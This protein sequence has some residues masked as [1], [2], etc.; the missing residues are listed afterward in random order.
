MA[1]AERQR[2]TQRIAQLEREIDEMQA[3]LYAA[4]DVLCLLMCCVRL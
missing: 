1:G 4:T 2:Q 3:C